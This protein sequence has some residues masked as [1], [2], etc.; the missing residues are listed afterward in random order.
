MKY[1]NITLTDHEQYLRLLSVLEKETVTIEIVLVNGEDTDAPL[2]KA[3]IPFLIKKELV[4]KWHGTRRGGKGAPKLTVRADKAVFAHLKKYEHFFVNSRDEYG[5]DTVI[6]TDFGQD[7]IAFLDKNGE[8]LF[9][10]T[11]HEGYAVIS[12]DI[13]KLITSKRCS[14][15]DNKKR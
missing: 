5:C 14:Q 7:D 13:V 4:N 15:N 6:E 1:D 12:A 10:T 11:T 3:V 8:P 2:I 9:F